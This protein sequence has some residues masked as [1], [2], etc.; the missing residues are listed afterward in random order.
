LMLTLSFV[1]FFLVGGRLGGPGVKGWEEGWKRVTY[2]GLNSLKPTHPNCQH[3]TTQQIVIKPRPMC[4]AITFQPFD[5]LN[6]ERHNR[7]ET[8]PYHD[9]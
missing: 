1:F 4:Q 5:L 6:N 2:C 3:S 7:H 9:Y 8:I